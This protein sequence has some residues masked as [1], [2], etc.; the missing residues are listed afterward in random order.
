MLPNMTEPDIVRLLVVEDSPDDLE[1]LVRAL[2]NSGLRFEWKGVTTARGF[3]DALGEA[4]DVVLCDYHLPNFDAFRALEILK[5][6]NLDL[7]FILV[8]GVLGEEAAV[9]VMRAGAHDFFAKGRLARLRPAIERELAEARLRAETRKAE[10][11]KARLLVELQ[12]ALTARDD[13][14]VLASH[15]LRTPLTILGLELEAQARVLARSGAPAPPRAES[16]RRQI[17]W[18][19][20]MVDRCFDVTKLSSE[21]LILS[22]RET[23]LRTVVVEVVERLRNWIEQA[24]CSLRLEPLESVVGEWDPVRLDS[25]VTNLLANALRFG[26]GKPI[27][28]AAHRDGPRAL[29]VVRD[30][31]IGMSEEE[32]ANLFRKFARAVPSENYGGLGLGLWVVDQVV[33]AHGGGIRVDSRKGEGASFAVDLPLET[34]DGNTA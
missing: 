30:Q 13:F 3:S 33:R 4:W 32:Q 1:L 9:A 20:T 16:I 26:A 28:V 23:D 27:T 31:G 8:S 19:A 29:L 12:R 34:V 14:L 10:A 7:P 22:R 15:E 5:Q 24:G 6:R 2:R 17:E 25:V 11:E 18:L 21:P